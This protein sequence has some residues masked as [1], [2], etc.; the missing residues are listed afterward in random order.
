MRLFST[1]LSKRNAKGVSKHE[2]PLPI[3][4]MTDTNA[5]NI[6]A[7]SKTPGHVEKSESGTEY[8]LTGSRLYLVLLGLGLA[9]YLFALDIA[10][11]ATVCLCR[12]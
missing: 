3:T 6:E 12:A 4:G 7:G 11:I 10:V 2:E 9:I 5:D 1:T 8:H